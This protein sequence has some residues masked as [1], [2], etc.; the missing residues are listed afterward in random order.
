MPSK[1]DASS[2]FT[3]KNDPISFF[4]ELGWLT[5]PTTSSQVFTY[6]FSLHT[7]FFPSNSWQNS[8]N[9]PI[10]I[11][12]PCTAADEFAV[13]LMDAGSPSEV[14]LARRATN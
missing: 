14:L 12:P 5:P 9:K 6:I 2:I 1:L 10:N 3:C 4:F 13:V 11:M 8:S 7:F